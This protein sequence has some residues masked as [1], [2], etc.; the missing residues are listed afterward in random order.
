M[1]VH[2]FGKQLLFIS[3]FKCFNGHIDVFSLTL[4]KEVLTDPALNSTKAKPTPQIRKPATTFRKKSSEFKLNQSLWFKTIPFISAGPEYVI[5]MLKDCTWIIQ[6]TRT[7]LL[8]VLH[9]PPLLVCL[10]ICLRVFILSTP[11]QVKLAITRGRS[12]VQGFGGAF[13]ALLF[14]STTT[15][16]KAAICSMTHVAN[17]TSPRS[18]GVQPKQGIV[19]KSFNNH[20]LMDFFKFGI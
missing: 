5:Q 15:R 18:I 19:L 4:M 7:P 13:R 12:L 16:E 11:A 2:R 1:N 6:F 17:Y 8:S 20:N 10:S 14:Y 3:H 9:S